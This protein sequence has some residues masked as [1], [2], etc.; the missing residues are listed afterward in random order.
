MSNKTYNNIISLISFLATLGFIICKIIGLISASWGLVVVPFIL[1]V[2]FRAGDDEDDNS[3]S[4]LKM[5]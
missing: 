2:I 1:A 3:G 4:N 5:A